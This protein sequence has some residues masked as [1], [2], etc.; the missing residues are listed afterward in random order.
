M[1]ALLSGKPERGHVRSFRERPLVGAPGGPIVGLD[2]AG[3]SGLI[4]IRV[5]AT[6]DPFQRCTQYERQGYRGT[7]W[8][9]STR[10][11]MAAEDKLLESGARHNNH[12]WSNALAEPG[13]VYVIQGR[14]YRS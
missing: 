12:R 14:R 4:R 11:M 3:L 2:H 1:H 10:N 6:I 7:M 13:Y 5:G 9:A 8:C